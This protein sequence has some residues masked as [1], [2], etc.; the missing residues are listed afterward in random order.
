MPPDALL[1]LAVE[2]PAPAGV[3][4]WM[5]TRHGGVS[6]GP[7]AS[8]NLATQVGDDPAAVAENRSRLARAVGAQ[9]LWLQQVHGGRV[10]D[11]GA[12]RDGIAEPADAMVALEAGLAC[13]VLVAD[14]LPVLFCTRDGRG[15]A[16]AHAGW[17]GLVAGVLARTVQTLARRADSRPDDL[18]AWL[19]PCI[20]PRQFEVGED[21]RA[22]FGEAGAV[23]FSPHVRRDGSP[24]W[25]CDL[26]ALARQQLREAGVQGIHGGGWCTVEQ[27]SG[28]FSFRRDRVCGRMA[29]VVCRLR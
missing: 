10:V 11:A 25:L 24:G 27:R 6:A 18:L 21:V 19:G 3:G 26:T 16:A 12:V 22:A 17:R 9:P 7:Y 5:T 2:W 14:C 29:A 20:G 28:F 23:H 15:V 8:L 13:T 1:G 4:A